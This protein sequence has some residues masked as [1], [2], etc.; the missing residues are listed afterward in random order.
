MLT[1]S[2]GTEEIWVGVEE[3]WGGLLSFCEAQRSFGEVFWGS[4]DAGA[5]YR[6]ALGRDFLARGGIPG[7]DFLPAEVF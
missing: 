7:C 2:Q 1:L 5:G 6:G 4:V 3:I